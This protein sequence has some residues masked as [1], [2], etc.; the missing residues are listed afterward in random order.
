M[1]GMIIKIIFKLKTD[2][3]YGALDRGDSFSVSRLN[4]GG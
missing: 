2:L 4:D 3:V 1:L